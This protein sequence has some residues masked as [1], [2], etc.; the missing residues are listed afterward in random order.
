MSTCLNLIILLT[1]SF[2]LILFICVACTCNCCCFYRHHVLHPYINVGIIVEFTTFSLVLLLTSA[3][4]VWRGNA[5]CCSAGQKL[6]WVAIYLILLDSALKVAHTGVPTIY[7]ALLTDCQV[8]RLLYIF[9]FSL[10]SLD[11]TTRK[12]GIE[13][14]YS[15]SYWTSVSNGSEHG[16]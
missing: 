14:V 5:A 1:P 16:I 9:Q 4:V 15:H 10:V 8:N 13:L 3:V 7:L 6:Q 11:N 2:L 12:T